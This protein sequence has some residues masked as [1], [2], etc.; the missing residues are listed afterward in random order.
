MDLNVQI[1]DVMKVLCLVV[2]FCAALPLLGDVSESG[3]K[4]F[5]AATAEPKN[6]ELHKD[7]VVE[8]GKSVVLDSEID[9]STLDAVAVSLRTVA[10]SPA[11][12][13]DLVVQAAWSVPEADQYNV[14][15]SKSGKTFLFTN[16]GGVVFLVY[17]SQMRLI[18][19]NTG[20]HTVKLH[21]VIVF[22][23]KNAK[24]PD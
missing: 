24:L 21:Q 13:T 1:L 15:E 7:V 10:D 19:R 18:L 2:V 23:K 20:E 22:T 5:R 6:Y 16:T 9:Y 3:P 8:A 12:V 4:G 11:D 14:A 17:G